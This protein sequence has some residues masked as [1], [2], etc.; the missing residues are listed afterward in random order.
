MTAPKTLFRPKFTPIPPDVDIA[1]L[2]NKTPNFQ[3]AH[4]EDARLHAAPYDKL[5]RTIHTVALEQGL[6]LV[7]DNWHLRNDWN[8]A[9]FSQEWLEREYG[10]QGLETKLI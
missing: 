1:N 2:V 8:A 10:D 6:P 9:L 3:W 7:V 4:R 5:T